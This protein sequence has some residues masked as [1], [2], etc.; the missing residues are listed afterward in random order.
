MLCAVVEFC[1]RQQ[2]ETRANPAS[3]AKTAKYLF[4]DDSIGHRNELENGCPESVNRLSRGWE[5]GTEKA[6]SV[7]CS[8]P[9]PRA[10]PGSPAT[11]LRRWGG[12]ARGWETTEA[13]SPRT[14]SFTRVGKSPRGTTCYFLL[15]N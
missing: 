12:R 7:H 1:A 6:P 11:G 8:V 13:H 4:I 5:Q 10:F 15:L 2:V 14:V 3:N 9:H